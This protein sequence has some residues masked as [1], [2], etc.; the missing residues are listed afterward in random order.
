M[1]AS[2]LLRTRLPVLDFLN[3]VFLVRQLTL[4]EMIDR[5]LLVK[6]SRSVVSVVGIMSSDE[7]RLAR[8]GHLHTVSCVGKR[9]SS[10]EVN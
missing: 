8:I 9:S 2:L 5:R 4:A 1:P 7:A 3:E 6:P 10:Q